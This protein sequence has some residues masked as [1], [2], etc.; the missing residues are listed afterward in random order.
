MLR[1]TWLLL[2]LFA[3][4]LTTASCTTAIGEQGIP[5]PEGP[6]GPAGIQGPAGVAGL[7]GA[8]GAAGPD[9][10]DFEY[11]AFVGSQTCAE[12]HQD[13]YDVFM[14]S[15]HPWQLN[16]ITDGQSPDY[17]YSEVANPPAGYAW[18]DISYVIGGYNWKALF[19]DQEGFIITGAE[20]S[21]T[22]YNLYNE[23]LDLGDDW[24]SYHPEEEKPYDC[25]SCHTTGYNVSGNQASLP[26]LIG[27][28]TEPGIQC[29]EC[30]GP[31][32][33]HASHPLTW[34]MEI[35]R[36]SQACGACHI[37][38][39]IEN[40]DASGGFINHH[41]QY[42]E[43]FQG[44]HITIDCVVC[45]DPH[46]GVVQLRQNGAQTT[47]T[48]CENC[49]FDEANNKANELHSRF[50]ECI[51]CHMPRVTQ[52]ALSIPE[53]YTGDLRTHLMAI[54]PT[55]IG[56]FSEDESTVLS[57]L[58]LDFACRGC[59]NPD[60][61]GSVLAD[62]MLIEAATNYH[63]EPAAVPVQPTQE[64]GEGTPQD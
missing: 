7:P 25:G 51:D 2:L 56:Q 60:G 12:C 18:D 30:H 45:H 44:K 55:Q 31:G 59:H 38:G 11:L 21:A 62:E 47:R 37:R 24:A 27:T 32:S 36:G 53:Q 8:P 15:G 43:L 48:T 28:W 5:G 58:G 61:F 17:P 42:E 35:D 57:Q 10:R 34:E 14:L 22:Q 64:E 19:I 50:V 29:E 63:T 4:A 46:A 33:L 13:T 9:G 20:E 1:Q 6:P 16:P 41:E 49:H 3:T 52:S 39:A 23:V 26:G 54:D 40:L